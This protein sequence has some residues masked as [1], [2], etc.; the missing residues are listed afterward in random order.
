M[1]DDVKALIADARKEIPRGF[2]GLTA[3]KL[4]L[5]QLEVSIA[6]LEQLKANGGSKWLKK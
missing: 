3:C 2:S 1:I 4:K 6:I 5:A